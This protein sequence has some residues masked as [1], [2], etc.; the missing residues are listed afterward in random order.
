VRIIGSEEARRIDEGT[1]HAGTPGLVLMER[2]AA[3]V[4]RE[5]ASLFALRPERALRPIV[6]AGTGNNGGDGFEVG[7]LLALDPRWTTP[8]IVFLGDPERIKGDASVTFRRLEESGASITRVQ[9]ETDLVRLRDATFIVD[10]LF[11][12]GLSRRL[13]GLSA[14]AAALS[15]HRAAFVLAVDLPSGL[16]GSL[17]TLPGPHFVADLTVTFGFPK[18]AH[19]HLPAAA[20]CGRVVVADI[21]LG[22]PPSAPGDADAEAVTAVTARDIASLFPRRQAAS[23]KG[24]YGRLGIFGG[25]MGMSGAPALAAIGAHRT[26]AGLVTLCV[27]EEI[28]NVVQTLS[29]E[30][31]TN[32]LDADPSRFDAIAVGPGL[33]TSDGARTLFERLIALPIPAVF[34]ADALNLAAGH[35]ELFSS[36][37]APTVLTPH[38]GEAAR[39]LGLDTPAVES[40][41]LGT[42]RR[43]ARLSSAIVIL[44]GF[45]SVVATPEGATAFVLAGNPGQANGGMGDVLTGIIGALLARGFGA[46]D[47][48]S[49]AAWLHGTAGDLVREEQGEEGLVASDVAAALPAAFRSIFTHASYEA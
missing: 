43:L 44:K 32:A 22:S 12:T 26:G 9:K 8:E 14:R 36:R 7:R 5:I 13:E 10:A 37:R 23:H 27:P 41:R 3:A 15:S 29:P 16:N 31:L 42:A 1:I 20:A 48:A 38:P 18:V 33:G 30:S 34:D 46:R 45:R 49:A 11:G 28:R 40:D 25:S 35:P 24:T 2:A 39:L 47:A 4:V 21:G 19:V 17:A 6:L